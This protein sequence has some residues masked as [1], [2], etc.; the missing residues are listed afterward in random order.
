MAKEYVCASSTL[1]AG[2]IAGLVRR[3]GHRAIGGVDREGVRGGGAAAELE[4][5]YVG[6]RPLVGE[7]HPQAGRPRQALVKHQG[8]GVDRHDPRRDGLPLQLN[9]IAIHDA[10]A[11]EEVAGVRHGHGR[12]LAG[13]CGFRQEAAAVNGRTARLQVEIKLGIGPRGILRNVDK[14]RRRLQ[15]MGIGPRD[16]QRDQ[17]RRPLAERHRVPVVQAS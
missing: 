3:L 11:I 4:S 13:R 12:P 1:P 9:G 10:V 7:T 8:V 17:Q 2:R 6:R 16:A 15:A 5:A 14:Q